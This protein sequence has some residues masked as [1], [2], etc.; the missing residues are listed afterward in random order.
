MNA[1]VNTLLGPS[2]ACQPELL[3]RAPWTQRLPGVSPNAKFAYS[4]SF[5][6]MLFRRISRMAA[7]I[8][9][10]P[11]GEMTFGESSG[12]RTPIQQFG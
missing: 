7:P 3:I 9:A 11:F 2:G 10:I 6:R 8:L 12:V 5:R 4:L 1:L